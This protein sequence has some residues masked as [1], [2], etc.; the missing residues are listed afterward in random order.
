MRYQIGDLPLTTLL[1][2][3]GRAEDQ[4]A[5]LDEIVRRSPVGQGFAERVHFIEAAA[6]MWV[7]G[8][9]VH[10]ED[11]VLH[12]ADRDVRAPT[13]EITIAHS[14]LR[15]RRRIAGAELVWATSMTGIASLMGREPAFA[16]RQAS[17]EGRRP[18]SSDLATD[19]DG[20]GFAEEMAE[21]DAV[22]DRSARVLE[23]VATGGDRKADPLTVG[24]LVVRDPEWNEEGR[25][26]DWR[27]VLQEVDAL[28]PT[29]AAAVMW[30]AWE[31]IEPL[32]RQ[33]WLGAQL[34]N[35][36]FR[37]CGK[38]SSHLFGFCSGLKAVPRERRRSPKRISRVLAGLEAMTSGAELA[39]KEVIRLGQAREHLERK[40]KGKRSSSSLP[41]V[42]DLLMTRPIVS[43]SMI[44]KELKVSHRA[45]LDLV[46]ELGVREVTGRASF[47]AWGVT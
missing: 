32:Q 36:Y 28:P 44:V 23:A 13:H 42:V 16:E 21:I 31:S 27:A 4:L 39:T 10:M 22:L 43:S 15:A 8:E 24:E 3:I 33:H 41:R 12:D 40:L 37:E 26:S 7:V 47:R 38:V 45:A 19:D 14:I 20:S 5:R 17:G 46:A 6:S 25:L 30:D 29:L 2:A 9:L 1:P 11:L 34:V 18:L 35:S